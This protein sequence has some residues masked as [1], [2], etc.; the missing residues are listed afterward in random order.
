M[1]DPLDWEREFTLTPADIFLSRGTLERK[2]LRASRLVLIDEFTMAIRSSG[3]AKAAPEALLR[4]LGWIG[5]D[6]HPSRRI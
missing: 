3:R 2:Y 5:N 1:K 4:G 6:K